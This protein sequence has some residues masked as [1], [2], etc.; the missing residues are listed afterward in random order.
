MSSLAEIESAIEQLPPCDVVA[1]RKWLEAR[2]IGH[3]PL[4]KWQGK[5][6]G[7]VREAGGVD[8]FLR[9]ARSNDDDRG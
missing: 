9:H 5:G 2:E 8:A 4:A 7:I 6:T 3:S 1:L